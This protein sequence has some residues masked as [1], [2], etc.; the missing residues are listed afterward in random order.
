MLPYRRVQSTDLKDSKVEIL[1]GIAARDN[2]YQN[3]KEK[4][5]SEDGSYRSFIVKKDD[6]TE[7]LRNAT[8][9]KYQCGTQSL[10]TSPGQ[11]NSRSSAPTSLT[12]I[13]HFVTVFLKIPNIHS[14]AEFITDI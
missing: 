5:A 11:T 8:F 1:A 3:N 2:I 4:R 9:L 7:I 13:G 14:E 6:G 12:N 10:G